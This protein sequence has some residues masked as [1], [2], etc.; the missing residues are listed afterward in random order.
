MGHFD[1]AALPLAKHKLTVAHWDGLA[2]AE[3]G[4]WR[5]QHRRLRPGPHIRVTASHWASHWALSG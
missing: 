3:P 2:A 5:P 4:C 1:R